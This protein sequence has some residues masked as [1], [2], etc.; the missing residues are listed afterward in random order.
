MSYQYL[1]KQAQLF[2][3]EYEEIL[4]SYDW[5]QDVLD[6]LKKAIKINYSNDGSVAYVK[7]NR[8][9]I[10]KLLEETNALDEV[11]DDVDVVFEWDDNVMKIKWEDRPL[12]NAELFGTKIAKQMERRHW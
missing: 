11:P 8:E 3:N 2:L 7:I 6:K 4:A 1:P 10:E 5:M 12:S 9:K